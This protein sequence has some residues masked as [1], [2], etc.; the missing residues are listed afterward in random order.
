MVL[1]FSIVN[2]FSIILPTYNRAHFLPRAIESVIKQDYD[3]W[4]LI[5]VDDGSTDNTKSLVQEFI[6][7]DIRI[8][9]I[10]QKNVE[11]SAARNHVSVF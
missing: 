1:H 3:N 2:F 9:Y 8:R 10:W 11:R 6:Q 5:I 4:E 7:N